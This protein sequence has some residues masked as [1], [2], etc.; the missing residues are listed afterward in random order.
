M[1]QEIVRLQNKIE[2]MRVKEEVKS[3]SP[4]VTFHKEGEMPF[5]MYM[6]YVY[7]KKA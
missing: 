4:F 1:E 2:N 7:H 5:E 6:A 3:D